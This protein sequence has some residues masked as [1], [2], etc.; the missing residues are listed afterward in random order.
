MPKG[1]RDID[2]SMK[3][4]DIAVVIRANDSQP[5]ATAR[6]LQH[7]I[8]VFGAHPD[9]SADPNIAEGAIGDIVG[10]RHDAVLVQCGHS[11][12]IW[13]S[14][15]RL[16]S[17]QIK[18]PAMMAIR[19][20]ASETVPPN[21]PKPTLCVP[22]GTFPMTVGFQ[23]IFV[24][25]QASV[26]YL[27]FEFY[28]G[29]MSTEQCRRLTAVVNTIDQEESDDIKMIVLLGGRDFFSNGIHLN[30]IEASND[31]VKES[32]DNI[33]AIDD[34]VHSVLTCQKLT[35]AALV[36]NAG[37]GGLMAALAADFT[38]THAN[39]VLVPSYK[40][41]CLFGSEYWTYTLPQRVGN[42]V[43]ARLTSSTDPISATQAHRL[44]LI[45]AIL[46]DGND[47]FVSSVVERAEI[48][49]DAGQRKPRVIDEKAMEKCR[50]NELYKMNLSFRTREYSANRH[51]FVTKSKKL[52]CR[53]T[54]EEV[55]KIGGGGMVDQVQH[56]SLVPQA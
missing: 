38:W 7:D 29:A 56:E 3:A 14:H 11:S 33:N 42:V 51:A 44:G 2:W 10:S 53:L 27:W 25:K 32:W 47:S 54:A 13:I 37:A 43:A 8:L 39:T 12:R 16:A 31:P 41:M 52:A 9:K 28:N 19:E 21:L 5:G 15:I 45:D 20:I 49:V 1:K 40:A 22:F 46:S 23:E 55:N 4:D 48:M 35:V 24:W 18:L 17:S 6:L 26:A 34:F 50:A 30:V 36:G